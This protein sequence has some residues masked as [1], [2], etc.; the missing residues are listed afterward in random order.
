MA[1]GARNEEGGRRAWTRTIPRGCDVLPGRTRG[2]AAGY[3]SVALRVV[4]PSAPPVG[5]RRRHSMLAASLLHARSLPPR[6]KPR[7]HRPR[8]TRHTL[9]FC[10]RFNVAPADAISASPNGVLDALYVYGVVTPVYRDST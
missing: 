3:V 1:D 4:T 6:V 5:R 2:R 8:G 10:I 9:T 7:S